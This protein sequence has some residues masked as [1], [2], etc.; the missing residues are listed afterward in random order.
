MATP[1]NEETI[2]DVQQAYAKA[3]H[4]FNNNRK[5]FLV[6]GGA[7]LAVVLGIF[8]FNYYSASQN[9]EA[10]E[11]I[12]KAEYYFEKDS[13]DKAIKGDGQYLGFEYI[14]NNYG[15]TKT[16][17]LAEYYLGLC[18]MA[19]GEFQTAIEHLEKCDF[20]DEVI[21]AIAKGNIGDAYVELGNVEKGISYFEEAA[22][23][24]ENSF[25]C[26]LYLQKAALAYEKLGKYD[27]AI[28][29]YT[30]IKE[31]FPNSA[32]GREVEKYIARAESFKK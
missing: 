15:S 6:A 7:V 21:G 31:E 12:W 13:L 19:K 10:K 22:E 8:G 32:E 25:T 28:K 23:H 11:L 17:Q 26:P 5:A 3:D 16:G 30:R 20:N 18:F 4:F 1:K 9:D 27:E 29:A 14:A 2:V 24:S